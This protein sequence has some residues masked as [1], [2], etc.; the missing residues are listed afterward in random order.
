LIALAFVASQ[1]LGDEPS[2]AADRRPHA[3]RQVAE[4]KQIFRYDT[5]GDEQLWTDFLRMQEPIG[6]AVTP[7]LAL[8]KGLKVDVE[9]LPRAIVDALAAGKV[10]LNDPA[11][12]RRLIGLNAVVGIKGTVDGAGQL[13]RV[14]I[15][16]ALCHSTVDD[17][18]APGI[19]KR[20]DGWANTDLD[21]GA[22]VALSPALDDAT[23]AILNRW[24]PGMYDPRHHAFDGTRLLI[25]HDTSVPVVIPSI[26]GLKNVGF[27]TYS[28]DGPISYWNAYVGIGQ[29]GGKGSFRD[30]R[31]G[32][33]ITQSPDLITPKLPALLAYQLSLGTPPA[34]A[35]GDVAAARRGKRLFDGVARCASCHQ[36]ATLTDVNTG[37]DRPVLHDPAETGMDGA[38]AARTATGK[39]RTTPLRALWRDRAFFHD[40]SA[41][42]LPAV[43]DHYDRHLGLGLDAAQ[44]RDLVAYLR[45]L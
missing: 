14:G 8:Q 37:G 36:G 17:S 3:T 42:S 24:G 34:P 27:E 4:G 33:T 5:F 18:F 40:G 10:D 13:T 22:I 19:G 30:D 41:A 15:T 7:A 21:V 28:A 32:L 2:V 9:A 20:L 12:T 1:A 11:V 29:M 6:T 23:K 16:C 35:S 44:K 39:Y 45:T 25:L 26:F 43:V 38:Y 31:I